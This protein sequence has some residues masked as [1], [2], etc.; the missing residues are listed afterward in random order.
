MVVGSVVGSVG[1]PTLGIVGVLGVLGTLGILG[2]P[3]PDG[4]IPVLPGFGVI[5]PLG[6]IF[7][8]LEASGLAGLIGIDPPDG[9]PSDGGVIAS[10]VGF[11]CMVAPVFRFLI[12]F[13]RALLIETA[14]VET[15]EEV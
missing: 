6:V 15:C 13:L 8:E 12:L 5:T 7:S 4:G 14:V 11:C 10:G 2:I 1:V 9:I 3:A